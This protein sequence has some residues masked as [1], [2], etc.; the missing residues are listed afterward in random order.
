MNTIH[1]FI[2]FMF[3]LGPR[4]AYYQVTNHSKLAARFAEDIPQD[5]YLLIASCIIL[6]L[7]LYTDGNVLQNV[8]IEHTLCDSVFLYETASFPVKNIF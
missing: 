3:F 5:V 6:I 1:P 7:M 4:V 2:P 8:T